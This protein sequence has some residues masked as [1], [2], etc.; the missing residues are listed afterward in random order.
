MQKITETSI[1]ITSNGANAEEVTNSILADVIRSN[2][3]AVHAVERH[4][5]GGTK[6]TVILQSKFADQPA[7]DGRVSESTHSQAFDMSGVTAGDT[8]D[9]KKDEADEAKPSAEDCDCPACMLRRY[10]Q[11]AG[12]VE[13]P[14][15]GEVAKAILNGVRVVTIPIKRG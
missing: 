7:Y 13:S 12:T 1:I 8:A 11:S 3:Y 4:G 10:L 6:A 5:S 9:P 2:S 15:A 14:S